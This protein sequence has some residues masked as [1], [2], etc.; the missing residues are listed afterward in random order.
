MS[1]I[2]KDIGRG[3]FVL[4]RGCD[5]RVGVKWQV[6]NRDGK[7]LVGK[8]LRDWSAIFKLIH[9]GR[10]V[11][12]LGCLTTSNGYAIAEIPGSAF[13]A[14]T[15]DARQHGEWRMVGHGPNG[16]QELLGWGY[17]ELV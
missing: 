15:W 5:E 1:S 2:S 11:Y 8:D 16:E 17:Y 13:E 6:D 12:E 14:S 7:G 4:H 9:G 3:D 10:S